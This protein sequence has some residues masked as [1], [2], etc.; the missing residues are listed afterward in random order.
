[1]LFKLTR[2]VCRLA[3]RN[4]FNDVFAVAPRLVYKF[5]E[6]KPAAANQNYFARSLALSSI[7]HDAKKDID[8]PKPRKKRDKYT[9][10]FSA[11]D[12]KKIIEYVKK[13]GKEVET[14]KKLANIFGR[15]DIN[16][17][18]DHYEFHLENTPTVTG[19]FSE[20]EDELILSFV[21]S[22]VKTQTQLRILLN[23][24]VEVRGKLY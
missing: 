21:E 24:L 14:W 10:G 6:V 7:I 15:K 13:Y 8:N 5:N 17:I 2:Q 16:A 22:M 23:S 12:D 9:T 11:D 20:K 18:R 3:L 4:Q 1:M 19:K